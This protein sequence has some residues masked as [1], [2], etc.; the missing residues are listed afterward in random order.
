MTTI[1]SKSTSTRNPI[2]T[3]KLN[4]NTYF[5]FH[6]FN[7]KNNYNFDPTSLLTIN[8][9]SYYLKLK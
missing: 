3:F 4:N 8:N 2:K 1:K 5:P 9:E 7:H 6:F